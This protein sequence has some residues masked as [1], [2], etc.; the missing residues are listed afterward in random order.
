M[1]TQF[2]NRFFKK[3]SNVTFDKYQFRENRDGAFGRTDGDR[4]TWRR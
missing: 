4:Q 3:S 2:L 1:N